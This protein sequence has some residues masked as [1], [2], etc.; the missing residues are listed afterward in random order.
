M[1]Q[2]EV[3]KNDEFEQFI[4]YYAHIF[5]VT[6]DLDCICKYY[7][8]TIEVKEQK[9]VFK[10]L[11]S[12]GH[13]RNTPKDIVDANK[14]RNTPVTKKPKFSE[15][16]LARILCKGMVGGNVSLE[17]VKNPHFQ[18]MLMGLCGRTVSYEAVSKYED[19]FI[20]EWKRKNSKVRL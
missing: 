1:F 6:S 2:K 10:H 18:K 20:E 14:P 5:I 17:K 12:I 3:D 11:K 16:E 8:K 9:D 7:N 13:K 15:E 4:K 19:E